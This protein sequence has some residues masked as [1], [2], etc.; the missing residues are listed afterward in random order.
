VP[1]HLIIDKIDD[2]PK[3]DSTNVPLLDKNNV[4]PV[5]LSV[6]GHRLMGIAEQVSLV[7]RVAADKQMGDI[8]RKISISINIKERLD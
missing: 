4:D 2:T 8:L 7:E 3:E 6:Y 1:E 5:L